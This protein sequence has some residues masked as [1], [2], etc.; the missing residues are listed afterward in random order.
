[1]A[2]A[3]YLYPFLIILIIT[4]CDD[5]QAVN[6][7]QQKREDSLALIQPDS[8]QQPIPRDS[9]LDSMNEY[10][11]AVA[12]S[13]SVRQAE[14]LNAIQ[15][16]VLNRDSTMNALQ[17]EFDRVVIRLNDFIEENDLEEKLNDPKHE[18]KK[19]QNKITVS[20]QKHQL[21]EKQQKEVLSE[22]AELNNMVKR[23]EKEIRKTK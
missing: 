23:L 2:K 1:M 21:T 7:G 4:G 19:L 17:I 18:I 20:L 22:I 6:E 16:Q 5:D 13:D 15:A 8:M 11:N 12:Q 9:M 10:L 14:L 3:P